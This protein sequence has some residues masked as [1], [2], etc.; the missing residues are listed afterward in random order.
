MKGVFF[1]V[2]Y[3][4]VLFI[5][6][7]FI[8]FLLLRITGRIAKRDAPMLRLV[9]SSFLGGGYSL[10]V[11]VGDISEVALLLSKIVACGLMI[12]VAFSFVSLRRYLITCGIF[13]ASN[14]I[15]LGV[16]VGMYMVSHSQR[17]VVHNSVVYL[18]ISAQ[19]LLAS[20]VVAYAAASVVVRLHNRALSRQDVYTLIVTNMGVRVVFL[21]IVDTGNRVREPFSNA[22]VIVV[23]SARARPLLGDKTR[24]VP[25]STINGSALLTAFKPDTIVLKSTFGQEVIEN[26][27]IALSDEVN[28]DIYSAILNPDILSV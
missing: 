7:F 20:A 19:L 11:L 18:D 14:Y 24:V 23:D 10:I 8:T 27:Y 26:A 16:V 28:D 4:D 15:M 17:I 9:L 3:A 2:I 5:I 6:N 22:P 12:L 13:L 1:I 25:V 21:A